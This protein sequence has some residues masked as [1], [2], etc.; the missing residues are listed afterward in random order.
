MLYCV[1]VFK[2]VAVCTINLHVD[3]S[4]FDLKNISHTHTKKMVET[5]GIQNLNIATFLQNE[6][7]TLQN[8]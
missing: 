5:G 8:A 2:D 4:D 7:V 1:E 6:M 3:E